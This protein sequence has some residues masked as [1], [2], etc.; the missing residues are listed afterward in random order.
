MGKKKKPDAVDLAAQQR[1]REQSEVEQ[2]FLTGVRTQRDF[3]APSSIEL[4]ASYFRLGAKYGRTMYVYGY[5]RQI[6]TG[7]LSSIINI[8]E[9]LDISMFIYP[10]DTQII[11]NNLR[12][13]VTQLEA[14]LSINSEKGKIRDPGL[15][16]ALS[17]AEE[18]RDQLQIGS[19]KFFR[20][21]LYV[22]VYADSLDELNFV[23]HKI[24]TIF[25][26]QLVFSKVA[27]S[28]QEQ[29]L[30]S[31]I[32][33]LTDQLQ[34]RRNMN[35]GAISTS[36]P[37]TSADLTDG[38][39]VLYG[40]NMHNNGLV[41]FDRFSLENA[42]MV[43]FAKSG[44]GKSFTVKLEALR[45]M[46]VGADIVIIDPE[47]E[48]QKLSD[49]VAGS[50][51]RLSLNSDTRIN[52]FDLP[53]VI[54]SDDADDALRANLVTLHG[55]LRQMLGG[56]QMTADG[57]IMTG[58]TAAEEA[59][60]DQA[61]IDTYAR[62][63][64]T[65]DPLTHNSTPPTIADLYDTL[66]HMGGTGPSLAQRLRK[67]TSGTFAGIFSQQSNIDI[68]NN[69]VVFNIRDLEDELRPVAM[70]IVL[71]HIWNITRTDQKRRMLIVD[72]AWQLMKHDDSANFL[73]S[74]AKRARKY[75][76]GL[77]TI[78]QD[79]EDFMGSKM[80]RAIV[81]N[82]SMQLLLK[83]SSSAVDVLSGVFKLTEEEQKRLANFPVGQG[84]FFA[85]Q[86]HVHIQ[87]QASE[88][89]YNLVN[90]SPTSTTQK[91]TVSGG[92]M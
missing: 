46:M 59:D 53:R 60:I 51:I 84:L 76:L 21:G 7:W 4:Q 65:S 64:I 34:I 29:G 45:S 48:Y 35:T 57:Q 36:F 77:T 43:V 80:G 15:Q 55:L 12:K 61:L 86:N 81:A 5:P 89:E 66:L 28:Q 68:N 39:G 58:L 8:D 6:Y 52:P 23:Q 62:V 74:L 13:K 82:S 25:G 16:A 1:V 90:T 40:I 73:F 42:N 17:D 32:P 41:I 47:N 92:Y 33:Q 85:G 49:A 9:V 10:V 69:M 24:E 87:I 50:Y 11:L 26:Q 79:V 3:I 22:T 71:N 20:Y 67:F 56:S 88:T 27:S 54:D 38:K 31:T 2:A 37:F 70:Y 78:S 18:L 72:E 75:Q 83:Q 91:P 44:A 63:G 19:E 14:S 30:N